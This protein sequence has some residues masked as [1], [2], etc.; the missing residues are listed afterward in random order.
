MLIQICASQNHRFG[1]DGDGIVY[2]YDFNTNNWMKLGHGRRDR[3]GS[4]SVENADRARSAPTGARAP[5][6]R[7]LAVA[8]LLVA[9]LHGELGIAHADVPAAK[10]IATCNREAP[11]GVRDRAVSPTPKDETGA[12]GARKASAEA[13]E[14]PGETAAVTQ[15]ADPQIYGME[16]EGAKDAA[17]RGAYRVCM[18]R[19]GF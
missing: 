18:R 6:M 4:P 5:S 7:T 12:G 19:S 16:G 13:V 9:G 3:G 15:S 17:Y 11:A 1:L 8:I 14:R 2:Q 10:D